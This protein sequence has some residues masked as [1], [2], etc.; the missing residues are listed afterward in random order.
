MC[1]CLCM[2]TC[3]CACISL[4]MYVCMHAC[5]DASISL[6]IV[7]YVCLYI[8]MYCAVC[9][10]LYPC[11]GV[12]GC[13]DGR[14]TCCC[15]TVWPMSLVSADYSGWQHGYQCIASTPC[16]T[17]Q[18]SWGI[19]QVLAVQG[20]LNGV[21]FRA[22][23]LC[24]CQVQDLPQRYVLLR[25]RRQLISIGWPWPCGTPKF[26]EAKEGIN[27]HS[28]IT[29]DEGHRIHHWEFFTAGLIKIP[30]RT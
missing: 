29:L 27:P 9:M 7:Q 30:G 13:I 20:R 26:P 22:P 6:C 16:P 25:V 19:W 14:R 5:L 28:E 18:K 12:L 8:S 11:A 23:C 15:A 1:V 21:W 24:K 2:Y 3:M 4:G 10:P 17:L